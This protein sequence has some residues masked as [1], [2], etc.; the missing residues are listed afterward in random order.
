MCYMNFDYLD[1]KTCDALKELG[2]P[3][4]AKKVEYEDNALYVP[5]VTIYSAH[6][7][8][9][10]E[11]NIFVEI[12]MTFG[13]YDMLVVSTKKEK[14]GRHKELWGEGGFKTYKEALYE[15]IK[16][17]VRVLTAIL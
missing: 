11:K 13:R 10:C 7:W 5:G 2:Y 9:I 1:Y 3:L 15:G 8:L 17:A 14:D 12:T 6:D 4:T 16:A